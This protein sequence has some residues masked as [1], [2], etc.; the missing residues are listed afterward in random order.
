MGTNAALALENGDHDNIG[1][2]G[3]SSSFVGINYLERTNEYIDH[4]LTKK[5]KMAM[6]PHVN[7]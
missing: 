2:L 3:F 6:G 1:D 4:D 7:R 5:G